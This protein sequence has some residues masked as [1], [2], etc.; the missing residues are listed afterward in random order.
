MAQDAMAAYVPDSPR[1]EEDLGGRDAFDALASAPRNG[2]RGVKIRGKGEDL[3]K[4]VDV[5]GIDLFK[6]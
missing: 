6:R 5:L 2:K 4:E 3:G 1:L